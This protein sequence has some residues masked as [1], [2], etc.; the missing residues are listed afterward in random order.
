MAL[1]PVLPRPYRGVLAVLDAPATPLHCNT[2]LSSHCNRPV[3]PRQ[4]GSRRQ[5]QLLRREEESFRQYLERIDEGRDGRDVSYFEMNLET[6]RQFWR[7][8][9]LSD[10]VFVVVDIRA[11]AVHLPPALFH[12]VV[13]ELK[14]T[15]VI[16][17]N[18]CDLVSPSTVSAWADT[19]RQRFSG[20]HVVPFASFYSKLDG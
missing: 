13:V 5:E 1:L 15:L 14:K 4:P 12:Q 3:F 19:L 8:I 2:A 18:K 7:V 20:V 9:E 6:W 10:I 16:L 17:L 11:P